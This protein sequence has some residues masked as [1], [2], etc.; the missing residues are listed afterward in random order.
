MGGIP[1]HENVH[2][3]PNHLYMEP[4]TTTWQRYCIILTFNGDPYIT[5]IERSYVILIAYWGSP[6]SRTFLLD[7][8]FHTSK[9]ERNGHRLSQCLFSVAQ[10]NVNFPTGNA[11]PPTW[12]LHNFSF[13]FGGY[14]CPCQ[15]SWWILITTYY[16]VSAGSLRGGPYSFNS[17]GD[18]IGGSHVAGVALQW[19][20]PPWYSG[21]QGT[22]IQLYGRF[23]WRRCV[24]LV[25]FV[26]HYKYP[27][28][29]DYFL[30]L[31]YTINQFSYHFDT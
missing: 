21:I 2:Q 25:P 29:V 26:I 3:L 28:P 18:F 27:Q 9:Q 11:R 24:P 23:W 10:H 17:E 1:Q 22:S 15:Y 19:W 5:T 31:V 6:H 12:N 7:S 4:H 16:M 20:A 13:F 30:M 14:R 8:E